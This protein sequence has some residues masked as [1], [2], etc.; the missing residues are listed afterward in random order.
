MGIVRLNLPCAVAKHDG[1]VIKNSVSREGMYLFEVEH[2]MNDS[3]GVILDR[4]SLKKLR[5]GLNQI[6]E[7][8]QC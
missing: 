1:L 7:E 4:E 3:M 8:P 6:L 2:Y 5:D